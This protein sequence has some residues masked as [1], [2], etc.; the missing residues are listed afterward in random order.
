MTRNVPTVIGNR[1][2]VRRSS[3]AIE[4]R[5]PDVI[6]LEPLPTE[7]RSRR[8]W[9]AVFVVLGFAFLIIHGVQLLLGAH[10]FLQ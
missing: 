10:P 5:E 7:G 4:S 6:D 3:R 9:R 8:F 2:P 1:L